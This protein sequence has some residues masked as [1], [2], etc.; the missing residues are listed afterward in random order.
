MKKFRIFYKVEGFVLNV[1]VNS[2]SAE[3]ARQYFNDKLCTWLTGWQIVKVEE[4][5]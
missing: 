1:D 2:N 3:E 4:V 5:A